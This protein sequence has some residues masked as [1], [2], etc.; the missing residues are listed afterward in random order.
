MALFRVECGGA[1]IE[2]WE[3]TMVLRIAM[4]ADWT[5]AAP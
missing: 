2:I 3:V 4:S 5:G 1:R